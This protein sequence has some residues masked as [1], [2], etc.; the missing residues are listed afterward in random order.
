MFK[1]YTRLYYSSSAVCSCYCWDLGNSI[2][3]G[4]G[5]AV[6]IKND[7][8][9]GQAVN[10]GKWD[11]SN[12]LT[13][14]FANEGGKIKGTYS[15]TTTV[16]VGVG[17]I[18]KTCG[19]VGLNGILARTKEMK[20]VLKTYCDAINQ[21]EIIGRMIEDMETEMRDLINTIYVQKSQ[22]IID[23]ARRNP[24]SVGNK[25]M[26]AQALKNAFKAQ[27]KP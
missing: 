12:I 19:N 3:E 23:L 26:Q 6:V 15:L 27:M 9:Q 25:M 24:S 5:V 20:K 10:D 11:S 18:S 14:K 2:E 1:Q 21:T 22:E 8:T 4:F 7:I 17:I 16:N 13:V